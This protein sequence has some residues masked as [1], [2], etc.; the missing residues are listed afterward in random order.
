MS[1]QNPGWEL[2]DTKTLTSNFDLGSEQ[3][4]TERRFTSGY[5]KGELVAFRLS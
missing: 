4:S 1:L 5:K 3:N 2:P